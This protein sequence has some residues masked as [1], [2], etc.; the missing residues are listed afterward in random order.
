LLYLITSPRSF[1]PSQ[2]TI[3]HTPSGPRASPPN[4][5]P[6]LMSFR[7]VVWT[8]VR[9]CVE[10]CFFALLFSPYRPQ[11]HQR[12]YFSACWGTSSSSAACFSTCIFA[13]C[14]QQRDR[15]SCPPL[16]PR[17]PPHTLPLFFSCANTVHFVHHRRLALLRFALACYDLVPSPFGDYSWFRGPGFEDSVVGMFI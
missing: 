14:L 17:Y 9:A 6:L 2:P 4:P 8:A 12:F 10:L 15:I 1:T 7:F 5:S 11:I 13:T 3:L 16:P